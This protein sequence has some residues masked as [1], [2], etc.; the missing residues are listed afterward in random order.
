MNSGTQY[1]VSSYTP[2]IIFPNNSELSGKKQN[3]HCAK[4]SLQPMNHITN[5]FV[6]WYNFYWKAQDGN[7]DVKLSESL[8]RLKKPKHLIIFDQWQIKM[9]KWEKSFYFLFINILS[10]LLFDFL[11]MIK[12]NLKIS[13][14]LYVYIYVYTYPH[15]RACTHGKTFLWHLW[16]THLAY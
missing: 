13:D 8:A 6:I 2:S 3:K 7:F 4:I 16:K 5:T 9:N 11:Q 14:T 15:T 1:L 12:I 10:R